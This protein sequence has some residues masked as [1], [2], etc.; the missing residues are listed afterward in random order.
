MTRRQGV[1]SKILL[2]MFVRKFQRKSATSRTNLT[3]PHERLVRKTHNEG[4]VAQSS[5]EL[6]QYASQLG[7]EP[8]VDWYLI[9]TRYQKATNRES[10][11]VLSELASDFLR[12][13]CVKYRR[14]NLN[15]NCLTLNDSALCRAPHKAVSAECRVM[16][17][18]VVTPSD[19]SKTSPYHVTLH[20]A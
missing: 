12:V 18:K 6:G 14:I 5:V 7:A 2:W 16:P 17:S 10:V 19:S 1:G 20:A 15:S 3:R 13:R 8:I 9:E 11:D 4:E